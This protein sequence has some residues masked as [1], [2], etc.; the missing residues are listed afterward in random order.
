MSPSRPFILRP[1]ATI[2]LMTAILLVGAVAY[3]QLPV[4]ALPQVD[5]PTIQV[6]TFYPGAS[7]DVMATTVTAPLERQFGEM[8]GLSQMTST[9]AGGVSVIVLQFNLSLDIDVA[10]EEVQAA[11]N[12]SQSYLPANLPTPPVYNKTNPADAPILTLGITSN[13]IP[14]S[15]VED[16]VDT[17]LAPKISQL[18]G[19]G[20]VSISGGQK[21]AVRIQVNPT[22]L[23][24]YGIN[25][26][27]VRTALTQT[28]VNSAKGN[29]D[30]P[31]QDYQINANDQI[32]EAQD[33]SYIVVAYRN[34]APVLL[35]DVASVVNGVENSQLA[36][37]MN[38]TP[39]VVLNIQR[40]PGANTIAVVR[41][42]KTLLPQLESNLPASVQIQELTDLTTSIQASVDD[43]E[44]ELM[45][46]IGLVVMVIFLFLRSIRATSIPFVAVPLSLVGTFGA[47]YALGYSLDNL[48]LM[49]LTIS[50]GFVVDDAIVMIENISR[51][52]EEGKSPMEAAL[53]GA[54]QIGFTIVSLTVSLIAVLI[55]LL[56][57]RDVV[58]RLFREF[59]VTLAVT[60]I[61]SAV[62]SLTLT[63]M[64]ASR[65]LRHNPESQQ[66]RWF[67]ASE[68][69]FNRMIEFYGRTLKVVLRYQT[70]TLLVAVA[71]LVLTVFLYIFIPKGF[72]PVQDTGVIQGISQAS[73]S[74]S[75]QAMSEKQQ[76]LASIILKDPAVESL[77]S[78][79]GADGTNT[80]LNSG[81]M[82]INLK[83][84]RERS[85]NASDVIRRLQ[86]NLAQVHGIH[87]Y[88]QPVQDITVDDRVS[89]T[90]YQ[91]T[92]E[93][94]DIDELD[95]WTAKFVDELKKLPSLEDVATDQQTNAQAVAV[96]IDRVTASRLGIAPATVDNTLYDAYGQ[97]Q[98]N[99]LYTQLNQYHVI[100]EAQPEWQQDPA[101]LSALYLQSN[102]SATAT[103]AAASTSFAASGSAAAGSNALT[104]SV[105]YTPSAATLQPSGS[106]LNFA[107]SQT[108]GS[109]N[110]GTFAGTTPNTVVAAT[111]ANAIPL[112]AFVKVSGTKESL[113]INHQG[114]FP[115]VTISFNLASNA[116]L[117]TAISDI[118]RVARNIH[119]PDSLQAQFQG[120]AASFENSLSN[121]AWLIL[122]ALV[123]VYIVLGVLYESF[124][125]PVTILSTLPSAGV[126]AL[127][128]LILFRQDLSVVAIIGIILLIGIVKKNGIMIV[129][130][131]L[132]AERQHGKNST[133]AI[134]E[135]SLLRFRPIMMTTMAA[136]LGGIPLALG[137]GYG[138]ELRRPL[139]IAMIGG[140]LVSQILTLYTTPVIYI[141]FDE[142]GQRFSHRK[143]SSREGGRGQ[144]DNG[145][146]GG[147]KPQPENA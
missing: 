18:N 28:S 52:L 80:T 22:K 45:L 74:I 118:N 128:A 89:R 109:L 113:S 58:G 2:L 115:S 32:T 131:A 94:P 145:A 81:R 64:M 4:S 84:I 119:F 68:R 135:A 110:A 127:L 126:G 26:E 24:S 111:S 59:A 85:L 83:P 19:V 87:L 35:K 96:N 116:A 73:Q 13:D 70:I 147:P 95:T 38:T 77:S 93:D 46:T 82:A 125:H 41:S 79:I 11:I 143:P 6:L 69:A 14:L 133:E 7:P 130:F 15:Q 29:F 27:D 136:L 142:L 51:Y 103:G 102:A 105:L 88:M 146:P 144:S 120:T 139:G 23:A 106:V 17:R 50:T 108:S 104:S 100:L 8:Q 42:I 90:Q 132:E 12:A 56:F 34:G 30:G 123:T 92:L 57:M 31:R 117:G 97:R 49:A 122:A 39:S 37:W 101:K 54:E 71:T 124:I 36:A 53:E 63:P 65:I 137:T 47:M 25:L 43:V 98:I 99:T 48:S 138:S 112:A 67:R 114:Q 16:L 121:E 55:P 91:Y 5:Y 76:Q 40:Q 1:V 134:Y 129:D 33:Y 75:F 20:L 66:S 141:F 21:P 61:I 3:R 72:F 140:L 62:V 44:F 107:S 78:F 9:S 10:G 60:I 86:G